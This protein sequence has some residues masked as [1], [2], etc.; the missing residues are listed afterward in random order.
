[1]KTNKRY[2]FEEKTTHKTVPF[3][4]DVAD[5]PNKH[6]PRSIEITGT[7]NLV[8]KDSQVL[9]HGSQDYKLERQNKDK[10]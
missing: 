10:K 7:Q 8:V 2:G 9:V 1:M 4:R 6:F 5:T 3:Y